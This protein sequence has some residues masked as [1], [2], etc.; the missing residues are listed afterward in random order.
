M[1]KKLRRGGPETLNLYTVSFNNTDTL[2]YS[3]FP[4]VYQSAPMDDGVVILYSTLPGSTY[5][6]YNL[7][8]TTTH[9]VG[10][11]VGLYHTFQG[12]CDGQ[13]D[14][15]S[16]TAPEESPALGC[17]SKRDTCI[18]KSGLDRKFYSTEV[19]HNA[20]YLPSYP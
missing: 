1:K 9:E 5:V 13:G 11:W 10:H 12:G 18:S 6:P 2:G 14:F 4:G 8:R 3:T 17:P 19:I 15:V 20:D 7:G 16:D